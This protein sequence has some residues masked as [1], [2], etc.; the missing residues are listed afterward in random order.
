[1]WDNQLTSLPET[2]GELKLLTTLYLENNP[3][4]SLP[5]TITNWIK[6]LKKRGCDVGKLG[7]LVS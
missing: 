2:I 4:S 7:K 1:M 6:D 3:L 5:E